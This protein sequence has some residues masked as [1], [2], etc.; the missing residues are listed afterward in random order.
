MIDSLEM[1]EQAATRATKIRNWQNE[2]LAE[3]IS[4]IKN[5]HHKYTREEMARLSSSLGQSLLRPRQESSRVATDPLQLSEPC[6]QN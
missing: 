3:L 6:L 1:A 5:T 2:P 4:H